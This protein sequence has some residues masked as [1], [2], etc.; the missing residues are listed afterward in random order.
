M[1][2][3]MSYPSAGGSNGSVGG[4]VS[5]SNPNSSLISGSSQAATNASS[6]AGVG[7]TG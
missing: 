2:T 5:H 7:A 4:N 3:P 1:I 6:M